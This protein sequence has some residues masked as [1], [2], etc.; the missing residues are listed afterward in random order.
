MANKNSIYLV[1]WENTHKHGLTSMRNRSISK[2]D[3]L[4]IFYTK[5]DKHDKV[6]ASIN[7]RYKIEAEHSSKSSLDFQLASYIGMLVNKY[8]D[9]YNYYIV[10]NDEGYDCLKSFWAN[11]G[12]TIKRIG[13]SANEVKQWAN[14]N[15][16]WIEEHSSSQETSSRKSKVSANKQKAT[17][18]GKPKI[19]KYLK[20]IATSERTVV[21]NMFQGSKSGMEFNNKLMK[22]YGDG[23]YVKTIYS[24]MK[25]VIKSQWS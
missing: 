16:K 6:L 15:V 21:N 11:W 25:P 20:N 7:A 8:G 19:S 1:D 4:I 14:S 10:S 2:D 22:Y 17:A 13:F 9:Q 18:S 3:I 5:Q 12:I 23:K 24:A